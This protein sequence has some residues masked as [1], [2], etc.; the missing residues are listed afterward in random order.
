MST[1]PLILS[2]QRFIAQRGNVKNIWSNN[3]SNFIGAN[4]QVKKKFKEIHHNRMN[5]FVELHGDD[6]FITWK[7]NPPPAS[8]MG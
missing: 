1:D 6:D 2:P 7:Q 5:R 4:D 8:R 3:E